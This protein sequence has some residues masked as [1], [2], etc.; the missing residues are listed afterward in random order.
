M[1]ANGYGEYNF[2]QHLLNVA[3][4]GKDN[5]KEIHISLV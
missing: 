5:I 2:D 3:A 1:L 4:F